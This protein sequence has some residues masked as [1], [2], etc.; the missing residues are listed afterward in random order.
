M[1]H[2]QGIFFSL[3]SKVKVVG[4]FKKD[5][6]WNVIRTDEDGNIIGKYVN[7]VLRE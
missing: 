2:G 6:E 1:F 7:G 4:E 3:P 5:R